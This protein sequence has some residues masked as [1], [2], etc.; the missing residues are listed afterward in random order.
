M[1]GRTYDIIVYGATGYTGRLV[2]DYMA[3]SPT[4][5]GL[6]W[7][8]AGRD[9]ARVNDVVKSF[10]T[11]IPVLRADPKDPA[12][13]D[14][15]CRS[16][17]V[18]IACVGPFAIHGLPAVDAC[19]RQGTHY[20]DI[21]GEFSFVRDVIDIFHDKAQAKG[22][23]L[24]PCC[25]FDS[26]PSDVGNF[27][28]HTMAAERG[29]TADEVRSY[30]S[31]KGSA[32]GGTM[33]SI[34]NLIDNVRR[35]DLSPVS[36]N[37]PDARKGVN[38]ATRKGFWYESRFKLFSNPFL[39]AAINERIVRR[40]NALLSRPSV[41]Y[42][43]AAVGS[44]LGSILMMVVSVIGVTLLRLPL[45]CRLTRR[46]LPKPGTGP[47]AEVLKQGKFR[48][49]FVGKTSKGD[50]VAEMS[51]K[52]DPYV[53]T[54]LFVA[55]SAAAILDIYV[56]RTATPPGAISGGVLT[57]ASAFGMTLVNRLSAAGMKLSYA[58]KRD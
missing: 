4:M 48:A 14:E 50:V 51:A 19:V 29:A 28:V 8:V 1:S 13:L 38:V 56:N 57:P 43:E 12:S 36:L 31:A 33:A 40:S 42:C 54:A 3:T 34:V 22:V 58:L 32:S 23:V 17:S 16:C 2:V 24:V 30:F 7:A 35:Q 26:V 25:G 53:S 37:P 11:R 10:P 6:K 47:S 39:M 18:L 52:Q 20:V 9:E 15:M 21:T 46:L 44:L 27:L 5:R 49:V 45:I 41:L 55:E